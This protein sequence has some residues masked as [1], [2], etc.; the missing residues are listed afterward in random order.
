MQAAVVGRLACLRQ[1]SRGGRGSLLEPRA[2]AAPAWCQHGASGP[3][4]AAQ[5]VAKTTT[6][7]SGEG[8][9]GQPGASGERRKTSIPKATLKIAYTLSISSPVSR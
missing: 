1:T 3:A 6:E 8:R 2:L 5:T 9:Q 4:A 7:L